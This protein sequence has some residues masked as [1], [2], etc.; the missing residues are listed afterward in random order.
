M[1]KYHLRK[2]EKEISDITEIARILKN[3]KFT[4]ISMCR[5]NE[6]YIVSL[7]YGFDEEKNSL[8][9]HTSL[10][11]LKLEFIRQNPNVCGTVIEDLGYV[12][13][14]CTQKYKSVVFRGNMSIVDDLDEK[15]HGL[16]VLLHHLET[17][18]VP[19]KKRN[20]ENDASYKKVNILRL[21][22]S[23]IIGKKGN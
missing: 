12:V 9:F 16:N 8:Y 18:P 4:T 22:I 19:I 13:D 6:P 5:S 21:D 14:E 15:K 1:Q 3:G 7:S 11:G 23:E 10:E 20:I 2:T 17:D